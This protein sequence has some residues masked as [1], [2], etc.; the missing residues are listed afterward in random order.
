MG[1]MQTKY[2][3]LQ[4]AAGTQ[5]EIW[6]MIC[7]AFSEKEFEQ[8]LFGEEHIN[9]D[10][11]KERTVYDGGYTA[12]SA[13]VQWFWEVVSSFTAR[14]QAQ[15]LE[16]CRGSSALP[17]DGFRNLKFILRRSGD[18]V[19]RLPEAHTCEFAVDLPP[20]VS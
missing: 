20:Y 19:G 11:W 3:P 2:A 13:V 4:E 8:L 6:F 16:F 1:E 17:P 14:D 18:D 9:C 15:L 10:T 12:D 7:T 5:G